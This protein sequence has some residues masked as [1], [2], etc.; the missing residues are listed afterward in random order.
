MRLFVALDL[1]ENI[2]A[3]LQPLL[4]NVPA[5]RSPRLDQ[6]HFTLNFI[7]EVP[8]QEFPDLAATLRGVEAKRFKL[9]MK[10]VGCFPS[11]NRPRILWAG[12]EK[13]PGLLEIK[14]KIDSALDK[15]RYPPEKRSF[16]PHITLSRIKNPH[17]LGIGDFLKKYLSFETSEFEVREFLLYSSDL[18]PKGAIYTKELTVPLKD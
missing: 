7:G 16:H 11:P 12:I 18:S 8:D 2:L 3:C 4:E 9:R 14:D 17:A 1:P 13:V 6:V 5:G 10:G 15:L